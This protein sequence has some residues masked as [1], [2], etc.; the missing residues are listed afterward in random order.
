MVSGI[1]KGR[2]SLKDFLH[3]AWAT[4]IVGIVATVV[5]AVVRH[6]FFLSFSCYKSPVGV[7]QFEIQLWFYLC[8][9][10]PLFQKSWPFPGA[11]KIPYPYGRSNFQIHIFA[12][13]I[14]DSDS[15]KKS[16]NGNYSSFLKIWAGTQSK[17]PK[18][19]KKRVS[20]TYP[21]FR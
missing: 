6:I 18:T 14:A 12:I 5:S 13:L 20:W 10:W 15:S 7:I 17:T 21:I 9:F 11:L 16:I 3:R 2:E 4:T 19:S 1:T 8:I